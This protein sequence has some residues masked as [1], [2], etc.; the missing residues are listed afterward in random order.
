M[1]KKGDTSDKGKALLKEA[2]NK[3]KGIVPGYHRKLATGFE[4]GFRPG[5]HLIQI[6]DLDINSATPNEEILKA[7]N[8]AGAFKATVSRF[9]TFN[10]LKDKFGPK[11][12]IKIDPVDPT[13]EPE[14]PYGFAYHT[15]VSTGFQSVIITS[16]EPTSN[17]YNRGLR[18]GM[19]V[20]KVDDKDLTTASDE[21][22]LPDGEK[23]IKVLL[24][25]GERKFVFPSNGLIA[26]EGWGLVRSHKDGV[27]SSR[28]LVRLDPAAE[29]IPHGPKLFCLFSS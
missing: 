15:Y 2:M 19:Q 6:N 29:P 5:D 16:V 17:A 20:L 14:N 7:V 9:P 1:K 26:N 13:L 27:T 4:A 24:W 3:A 21:P 10:E 28:Y 11:F 8:T 23:A 22:L 18:V 25:L 12:R